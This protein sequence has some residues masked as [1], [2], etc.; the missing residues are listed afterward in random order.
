MNKILFIKIMISLIFMFHN[1]TAIA[2]VGSISVAGTGSTL[3]YVYDS[4][5]GELAYDSTNQQI[6]VPSGTYVVKLNKTVRTVTVKAGQ[7]TVV[8]AGSISVA[9]TGST[10]FYVYDSDSRELAYDSTNKQIE[11]FPGTYTVKL[12]KTVRTAEV[13]EGKNTVIKAGSV[14][15]AGT[16]STLF[17]VYDPDFR[18]LAYDSTNQQIE[19]FPGTYTVKLNKTVR[20]AEV[21]EGEDTVV[22]A[23]SVSVAGTGS[24]LFYVYGLISNSINN[25]D[26]NSD[27]KIGLEEAIYAL[28]IVSGITGSK[29]EKEFY[30]IGF[31]ELA[32]DSTNQQ[33]ELFPGTY[34]VE[35]NKTVRTAEVQEGENTVV[36]AGSVSVAG[37]GSTLFYV[38][39]SGFRELAYDST[40]K[41]VE[42]F[43]G[44]Y[45]VELN[46]TVRTAEVQEGENTVVKAGSVSVAG[47]GSTLFYVYDSG[48]RELAYDS[49]NKQVELFPGNYTV[50][51]NKN[52]QSAVVQEGKNTSIEF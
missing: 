15:V 28:Q 16:G 45:T 52:V 31:F 22:K 25:G 3:F 39:D 21:Q 37:T 49:T 30:G 6:E 19:L 12:N 10:L 4:S 9:G 17:Y 34:T 38:Y 20:T 18:E 46:K 51:L 42:L 1:G 35:L 7:N 14:S 8:K 43:P 36:K 48:F 32:Y 50:K 27:G 2:Q 40:N 47:T 23:G 29:L 5:F 24:T 13:Q 44:T 41:Q 33:I 26:I 11:L